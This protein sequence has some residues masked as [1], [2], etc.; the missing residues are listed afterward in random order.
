MILA[1]N[2]TQQNQ[3][4]TTI[5]ACEIA[6]EVGYAGYILAEQDN[7]MIELAGMDPEMSEVS[8]YI[9]QNDA[10][11]GTNQIISNQTFVNT[12]QFSQYIYVRV[13]DP[14]AFT[15]EIIVILLITEDC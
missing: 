12:V 2:S 1:Q 15:Y 10:E 7:C 11:A 3:C 9:S 6:T 5:T 4:S 8:Y 13:E 14:T